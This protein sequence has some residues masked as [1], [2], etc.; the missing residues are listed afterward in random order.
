MT[1]KNYSFQQRRQDREQAALLQYV[2]NQASY[3]PCEKGSCLEIMSVLLL[4]G[5][6]S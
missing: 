1:L 6:A 3:L 2:S 5:F 4:K